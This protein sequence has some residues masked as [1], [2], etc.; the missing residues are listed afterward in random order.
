MSTA[1]PAHAWPRRWLL[2]AFA[3]ADIWLLG[4][5]I[6]SLRGGYWLR[7]EAGEAAFAGLDVPTVIR[8]QPR[9]GFASAERRDA[10]GWIWAPLI[11][12]D[13]GVWHRDIDLATEGGPA[14]LQKAIVDDAIH[15]DDPVDAALRDALER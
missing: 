7:P 13:R 8:W 4:Y 10:L 15:P 5:F 3:I 9:P 12:L 14:R 11:A 1:V 6:A 2:L